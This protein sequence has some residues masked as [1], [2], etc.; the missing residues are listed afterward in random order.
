MEVAGVM[1]RR[2]RDKILGVMLGGGSG[3]VKVIGV[4]WV[5]VVGL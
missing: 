4:M 5:G 3:F 2:V 1:L